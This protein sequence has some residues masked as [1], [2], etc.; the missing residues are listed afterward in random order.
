MVN[1][2]LVPA[3]STITIAAFGEEFK[4][5]GLTAIP[6]LHTIDHPGRTA[7]ATTIAFW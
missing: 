5:G 2:T 3:A 4:V 6:T 1:L 7:I